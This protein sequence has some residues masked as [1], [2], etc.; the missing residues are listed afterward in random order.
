MVTFEIKIIY[1]QNYEIKIA[2]K[3]NSLLSCYWRWKQSIWQ[4]FVIYALLFSPNEEVSMSAVELVHSIWCSSYLQWSL[5][6]LID[7]LLTTL[8]DKSMFLWDFNYF[9]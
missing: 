1:F 9:N 3:Y 6:K 5:N 7:N 8:T 4:Y 2:V